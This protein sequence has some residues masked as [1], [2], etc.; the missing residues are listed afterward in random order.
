MVFCLYFSLQRKGLKM[1][2]LLP[3]RWLF[4]PFLDYSLDSHSFPPF[5]QWWI[6]NKILVFTLFP[7]EGELIFDWVNN[8]MAP[9][10]YWALKLDK[11]R[12]W[13]IKLRVSW[14][15]ELVVQK[16]QGACLRH[17]LSELWSQ[18]GSSWLRAGF[19][20]PSWRSWFDSQPG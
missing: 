8:Y 2:T 1:S 12:D 10:F 14:W 16:G 19:S 20:I 13:C 17:W 11:L 18:G 15:L 3:Q 9:G 5:F 6:S 4:S 7:K